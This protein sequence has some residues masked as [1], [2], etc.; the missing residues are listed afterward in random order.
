MFLK[1]EA[2]NKYSF[3]L[4]YKKRVLDFFTSFFI[5][6]SKSLEINRLN[7]QVNQTPLF[8]QLI[9]TTQLPSIDDKK[10]HANLR[11]ISINEKYCMAR[12]IAAFQ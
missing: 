1:N 5:F 10:G 8:T 4:K 6:P 9:P 12:I 2:K 7:S 3:P 11:M